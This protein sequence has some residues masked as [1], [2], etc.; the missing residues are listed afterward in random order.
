KQDKR[1]VRLSLLLANGEDGRIVGELSFDARSLGALRAK[2][3]AQLWSTLGPLVDQAASPGRPDSGETP[4]AAAEPGTPAG[5]V[6]ET[7]PERKP[8]RRR[9]AGAAHPRAGEVPETSPTE[10]AETPPGRK[11]P[12]APAAGEVPE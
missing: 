1:D 11:P 3:K 5:E 8:A 6:P 9:P 4:I 12:R 10:R 7:S 2:V